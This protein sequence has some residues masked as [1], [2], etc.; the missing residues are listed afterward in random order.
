[1]KKLFLLIICVFVAISM[2]SQ[3]KS[4]KLIIMHTNDLHSNLTGF[5]PELEYTPCLVGDDM[6]KAGFSRIAA[7]IDE[8]RKVNPDNLL[9]VDAGDFLMGTFFHIF[10]EQYGFEL[11]L[12]GEMGYDVV[13]LGNHEFDFGLYK[14]IRIINTSIK[15]SNGN[16]PALT[17]ANVEFDDKSKGDDY[18]FKDLYN[19]GVIR[20]YQIVEKAGFKIGV[21]GLIGEDAEQVAPNAAPLKFTDRIKTSKKIVKTLL[22]EEQVDIVIC[23][24]HSGVSKDKHGNWTGEDVELAE[25]VKGIDV[26]VSGHT[27]TEIFDPIWVGSTAI[28]QT[29]SQGKNIGRF[30]LNIQNGEIASAKYQLIPVDDK[31]YGDC[32]IHQEI[33]GR[34]KMIDDTILKPMGLGYY[35]ALAETD[36]E[37]ICDEQADLDSSNLGPVISDA[38]IYYVN[39]F[40]PVKT[41]ISLIA[42][43]MVRDMIRVG[44][45]GVQTVTDVFRVVSLGEGEDNLPGY[46]LAQVYLTPKEIK[47]VIELLLVAPKMKPSYYCFY[48]G[49]TVYYDDS[50]GLLRKIQKLEIGD[51]EVDFSKKNK[52]LYSL[53][54]NSYM[55]EFVS[56][57]KGMTLG[58]VKVE[59]KHADGTPVKDN[60][61]TWID[62]D[63]D[64]EGVQEGKEWMAMVKYLQSFPDLNGNRIPDF[65]EMYRLPLI[66]TIPIVDKK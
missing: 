64:K 19:I 61:T 27:H 23:L 41:D 17:L 28:V 43:G 9:L 22:E 52:T 66:R 51:K 8:E 31:I 21:F 16:I 33:A 47:N 18:W 36:Y 24:S 46:P 48:S 12:M 37:L 59:P 58:L 39:N 60:K 14:L 6:T 35:R 1:M 10:E 15:T 7:I 11:A 38:I 13:G 65:P 4:G 5:S 30:E 45:K 2:F 63:A 40:S 53:T 3:P 50:K 25:K 49:L 56:E 54:A 57:I 55:L 26:I 34:I 20:P 29:G 42:A 32:K 62:F 44:N